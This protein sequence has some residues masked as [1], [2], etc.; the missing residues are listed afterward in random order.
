MAHRAEGLSDIF[1]HNVTVRKNIN[2]DGGTV[3]HTPTAVKDIANKEYVDAQVAAGIS[4]TDTSTIDLTLTAGDLK[5]DTKDG[6]ID[7]NALLNTHNLTTDISH[8]SIA[9]VSADDHHVE[10]TTTEHS[11]IGDSAPH[12]AESHDIASHPDTS[13]TGTELDTLTDNS[14]A[15]T[16]HRHSELSASDG[17]PDQA[18]TVDAAGKVSISNDLRVDTDLL[19][20]DIAPGNVGINTAIPV[21]PLDVTGQIHTSESL[22]LDNTWVIARRKVIPSSLQ[23]IAGWQAVAYNIGTNF[24][25]GGQ[26]SFRADGGWSEFSIPTK[27][28]L[29]LCPAGSTTLDTVLTIRQDGDVG[30]GTDNPSSKLEVA[31]A[32]STAT[33]TITES[34]DDTNVAGI[35][36]LFVEPSAP[37]PLLNNLISYWELDESSGAVL[38]V[39]GSNNGTNNGA[40]PNVAGKINT[41]YD[42]EKG[43]TDYIDLGVDTFSSAELSSGTLAAWIKI[44][45]IGSDMVIISLEDLVTIKVETNGKPYLKLYDGNT[46]YARSTEALSTGVWYL[47]S[48]TWNG[49]TMKIFVNGVE[50]NSA[51]QGSPSLDGFVRANAIGYNLHANLFPFDGIIDECMV[52][53]TDL[54]STELTELYNSG[55]GLAYPFGGA[56]GAIVIGGFVGG[57]DGQHL[58]ITIIN[59]DNDVTLEHNEGGVSQPILLHRGSDETIDGH[60]GGWSLVCH[61][62]VDWHDLSHAKHV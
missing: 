20:V 21:Y 8:D 9:D 55:D 26:M 53:G 24:E 60:F 32:I 47:I 19:F 51:S 43:E 28:E 62:G 36:T 17:T 18:L 27:L 45:S 41:A 49:T 14:M 1:E 58:D 56:G 7:H 40:T 2:A 31:G 59:I 13:A 4:V 57:V 29:R 46:V 23:F 42:F 35:N 61:G 5:A 15:D 22:V 48:G 16:L 33:A 37:N 3:Q 25:Q 39:H 50:K 38:D 54:D 34:A 10:F 30:I 12:H 44:E 52:F 11:A 6:G